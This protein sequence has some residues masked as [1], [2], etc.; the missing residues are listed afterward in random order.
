[1]LTQFEVDEIIRE[2]PKLPGDTEGQIRDMA[3]LR[4]RYLFYRRG[5]AVSTLEDLLCGTK[6]TVYYGFCTH[7]QQ[8][9]VLGNMPQHNDY[10]TCPGCGSVCTAKKYGLGTSHLFDDGYYNLLQTSGNRLYI[11]QLYAYLDYRADKL[12]PIFKYIDNGYRWV[13][14]AE[15]CCKLI[16]QAH[17]YTPANGWKY[18]WER[19]KSFTIDHVGA[20]YPDITAELLDGTYL[21]NSHAFDYLKL[22]RGGLNDLIRYAE[23]YARHPNIESFVNER[24]IRFAREYVER[25]RAVMNRIIDWKKKRPHEMLRIQKEELETFMQMFR[26]A[27]EI[28]LCHQRVRLVGQ[29]LTGAQLQ[30]LIGL[31]HSDFGERPIREGIKSGRILRMLNYLYRQYKAAEK[32]YPEQHHSLS[33]MVA[34]WR[35]YLNECTALEYDLTRDGVYYP[36]DL[37]KQHNR[38]MKL[39]EIKSDEI[40]C[41]KAAARVAKLNWMTF[42]QDGLLIRP[43][44]RA[45]ALAYEG[46]ALDHCVAS[47]AE[48]HVNG[49]TAIFFIRKSA[50]PEKSYFTLE[51]NE[52]DL[53][54]RQNRGKGNCA[55][56]ESVKAFVDVWLQWLPAER[57]RL[58]RLE[59][60]QLKT[61]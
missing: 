7:C 22:T 21:K 60:R 53:S 52:K 18:R 41:K 56:P 14:S 16:Q 2:W 24:Y 27:P 42:E 50:N 54:I 33:S 5:K 25:S 3:L 11:R 43:A 48:R 35:D 39:I 23:A 9:Y 4:S 44:E 58:D 13:L 32:K 15:G 12:H 55:P 49:Q 37:I 31:R 47:Y 17:G 36:P 1:M 38:T 29:R 26:N 10:Y 30:T 6:S 57:K 8:Q 34:V 20:P 46:K 45:N 61:A 28:A 59:R 51:L 40:S 19:Q